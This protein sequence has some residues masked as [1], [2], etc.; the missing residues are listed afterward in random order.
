MNFILKG[1]LPGFCEVVRTGELKKISMEAATTNFADPHVTLAPWKAK[2]SSTVQI[3][4][5][6]KSCEWKKMDRMSG[7]GGGWTE[8][9]RS[10]VYP[11]HMS[12]VLAFA[13][14]SSWPWC[15]GTEKSGTNSG[16]S[17]CGFKSNLDEN[18]KQT[19][20]ANRGKG[21][22]FACFLPK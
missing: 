17:L 10:V 2:K 1:L 6:P 22:G 11:I 7:W 16:S 19:K 5:V 9:T 20:T 21:R 15:L 13:S 4:K 18:K 12:L 3:G 14:G 8:T